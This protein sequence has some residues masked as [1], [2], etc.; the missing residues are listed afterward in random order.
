MR[1][2]TLKLLHKDSTVVELN[3]DVDEMHKLIGILSYGGWKNPEGVKFVVDEYYITVFQPLEVHVVLQ[4]E[5]ELN[6]KTLNQF[7]G[8]TQDFQQRLTPPFSRRT[9]EDLN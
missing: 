4:T 7:A 1:T 2:V 8:L 6:R 5:E 3:V 9:N